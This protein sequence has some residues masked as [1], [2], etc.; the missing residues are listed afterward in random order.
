[1][2]DH[3]CTRVNVFASADAAAAIPE[4]EENKATSINRAGHLCQTT[5]VAHVVHVN[6]WRS[7]LT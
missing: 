2:A 7:M 6:E 5:P 3:V 4:W 1:M